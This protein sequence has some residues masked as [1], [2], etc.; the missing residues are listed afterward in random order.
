MPGVSN[1]ARTRATVPSLRNMGFERQALVLKLATS[2]AVGFAAPTGGDW[3][4]PRV[5]IQRRTMGSCSKA[6]RNG[7]SS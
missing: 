2:V 7:T 1:D 3:R 4:T 5:E 6:L